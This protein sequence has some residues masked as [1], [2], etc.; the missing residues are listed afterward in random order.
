MAAVAT[1]R[2]SAESK[3]SP[4]APSSNGS[5][6]DSRD[7]ET[8]A[9]KESLKS[10]GSDLDGQQASSLFIPGFTSIFDYSSPYQTKKVKDTEMQR[11]KEEKAAAEAS[12]GM[13]EKLSE[14]SASKKSKT[15]KTAKTA[16]SAESSPSELR[17][18]EPTPQETADEEDLLADSLP[19][20]SRTHSAHASGSFSEFARARSETLRTESLRSDATH[21]RTPHAAAHTRTPHSDVPPQRSTPSEPARARTVNTESARARTPQ[22]DTVRERVV[23]TDPRTQA[24]SARADQETAIRKL[25]FE[26]TSKFVK[27]S[28]ADALSTDAEIKDRGDVPSEKLIKAKAKKEIKAKTEAM[29]KGTKALRIAGAPE[30]RPADDSFVE[31]SVNVIENMSILECAKSL[32]SEG[33]NP[34]VMCM[35]D[36]YA[37]DKYVLGTEAQQGSDSM[38]SSVFRSTNISAALSGKPLHLHAYHYVPKVQVFRSSDKM[39]NRF[40][41]PFEVDMVV[42]APYKRTDENFKKHTI[43]LIKAILRKAAEQTKDKPGHDSLVLCPL[44][45]G[46][47]FNQNPTDIAAIF[48]EVLEDPEFSG[49]FKVIMFAIEDKTPE[50]R[51][52]NAFHDTFKMKDDV[53]LDSEIPP[54]HLNLDGLNIA[55]FRAPSLEELLSGTPQ[56]DPSQFTGSCSM[57]TFAQ[58]RYPFH[59]FSDFPEAQTRSAARP[60]YTPHFDRRDIH[61]T[62]SCTSRGTSTKPN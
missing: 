1:E 45:C 49:I 51:I 19:Q 55:P 53:E 31:T 3:R 54:M 39:Q 20:D 25:R 28:L 16:S 40:C 26:E 5:A 27:D 58:E 32:I 62:E 12:R 50:R 60:T 59:D 44:G 29:I 9:S 7:K 47:K 2:H 48:K 61:H 21:S 22:S 23:F 4:T 6:S 17:R 10:S 36:G 15:A 35:A 8:R 33:S 14:K 56:F 37:S 11:E 30:I 57:G 41:D 46:V 42:A 52:Y 38:E 18:S 13:L 43:T 34:L 24:A